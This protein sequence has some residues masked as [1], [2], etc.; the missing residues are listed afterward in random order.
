VQRAKNTGMIGSAGAA[1]A[2]QDSGSQMG[3]ITHASS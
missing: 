2:E 3:G 1:A